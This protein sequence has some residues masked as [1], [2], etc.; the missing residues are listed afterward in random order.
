M[1]PLL[2]SFKYSGKDA[3]CTYCDRDKPT[4]MRY[5]DSCRSGIAQALK[6]LELGKAK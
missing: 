3:R 1:N 2:E 5:C 4:I 6:A